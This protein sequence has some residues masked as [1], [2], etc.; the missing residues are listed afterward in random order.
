MLKFLKSKTINFGLL[1][2]I[3]GVIQANLA[4]LQLDPQTY[5]WATMGIGIIVVVLRFLTDKPVSEK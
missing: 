2:A 5:G 1:L 3:A 4:L